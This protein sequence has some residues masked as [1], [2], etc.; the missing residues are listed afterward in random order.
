[1]ERRRAE[2]VSQ[3][4]E[5]QLRAADPASAFVPLGNVDLDAIFCHE[6]TCTMGRDNTVALDRQLLAG[7][8]AARPARLQP[9]NGRAN[10]EQKLPETP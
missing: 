1:V 2:P 7:G 3:A 5:V 4:R 10:G 9:A 6:D 8:G